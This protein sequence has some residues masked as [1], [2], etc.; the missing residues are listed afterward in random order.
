M[1]ISPCA[2]AI[3]PTLIRALRERAGPESIDL[4]LGQPDLPVSEA[5]RDAMMRELQ[6]PTYAPY[7]ANAGLWETREAVARHEGALPEEVLVTCGVQQ[8]LAVALLGLVEAGDEVLV[9]DPGF[10]AYPNL[11][12]AAGGTPVPYGLR[13]GEQGWTLDPAAIAAAISEK[14][15]LIILNSPSNPTGGIHGK[16]ELSEVLEAL[17]ERDIAWLSDEI[18]EDYVYDGAVHVSP[19][20]FVDHLGRGIKLSGLS[21]SHHMMGWRLGWMVGPADLIR[22]LTPLHQHLV[23]CAPTL[24]QRAAI[25]ALGDH[26]PTRT[27]TLAIFNERRN[28]AIA[29]CHGLDGVSFANPC[30]AFY[31]F[32]DVR[33]MLGPNQ[34]VT[35]LAYNILREV[36]VITIPGAGFGPG[37]EGFLRIAYTVESKKVVEG[38]E[39]VRHYFDTLDP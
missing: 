28:L 10:P 34:F 13:P 2:A 18:Y 22:E 9:P 21:K 11:V 15:K 27:R 29:G 33:G 25:A 39:R 26:Y 24:V 1:K 35:E 7:S 6:G 16:A 23:T 36:D 8:G 20:D 12:R 30:G 17:A 38:L 3:E 19:R 5:V 4:G 32:A 31:L 14:T 37:G